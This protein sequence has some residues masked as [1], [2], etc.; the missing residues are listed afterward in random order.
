MEEDPLQQ[1][2]AEEKAVLNVLAE[3]GGEFYL[4]FQAIS[5]RVLLPVDEVR[6]AC[7]SLRNQGLVDFQRG[8]MNE[9]GQV[10][11]SGYAITSAGY[12]FV[13][14]E[15]HDSSDFIPEQGGPQPN[16][17]LNPSNIGR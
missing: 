17:D 16:S 10:A 2:M 3:Y 7:R 9:D 12:R 5:R 6:L 4:G 15:E 1:L 14:N 8:L 11:G 13:D